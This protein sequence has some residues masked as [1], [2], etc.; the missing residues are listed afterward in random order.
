MAKLKDTLNTQDE[1]TI[2]KMYNEGF[3][4]MTIARILA[5]KGG[6]VERFIQSKGIKRNL[7]QA[8]EARKKANKIPIENLLPKI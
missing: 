2:I 3:G 8:R 6:P 4:P 1:I 5:I 7:E